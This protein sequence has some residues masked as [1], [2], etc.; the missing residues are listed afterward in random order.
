MTSGEKRLAQRLEAKLDDDYLLWYDVPVGPKCLHPDFI[1]LHP[2]RGLFVRDDATTDRKLAIADWIK[3]V[4][5]ASHLENRIDRPS[6]LSLS[7]SVTFC[8]VRID[9]TIPAHVTAQTS[10][11]QKIALLTYV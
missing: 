2:L 7:K 11:R 8:P 1:L 3:C 10:T 6:R 5:G 4:G 9:L